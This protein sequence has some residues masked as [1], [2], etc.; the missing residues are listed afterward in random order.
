MHAQPIQASLPPG[1]ATLFRPASERDKKYVLFSGTKVLQARC[2][3]LSRLPQHKAL[4]LEE[5]KYVWETVVEAPKQQQQQ[6]QQSDS[7]SGYGPSPNHSSHGR[8]PTLRGLADLLQHQQRYQK[9]IAVGMVMRTGFSTARGQL[10]RAILFPPP[11]KFDFEAQVGGW[12]V[13]I[14]GSMAVDWR[15]LVCLAL[16]HPCMG[17]IIQRN[18]HPT[19]STPGLPL[20]LGALLGAGGGHHLPGHHLREVSKL[21]ADDA[22]AGTRRPSSPRLED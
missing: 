18:R 8:H 17:T 2:G 10:V 1:D 5:S 12:V 20:H 19:P 21:I 3:P 22:D 16:P 7:G 15:L 6:Q 9:P 14:D 4:P 13:A 11:P